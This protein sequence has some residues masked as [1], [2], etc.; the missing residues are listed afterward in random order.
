MATNRKKNKIVRIDLERY[1]VFCILPR[2]FKLSLWLQGKSYILVTPRG[3]LIIHR[4]I[5]IGKKDICFIGHYSRSCSN[6]ESW[7]H[8][9][10]SSLMQ[11]KF[12]EIANYI[13]SKYTCTYICVISTDVFL[14]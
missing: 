9:F 3:H 5:N 4:L 10:N 1:L 8:K 6:T 2:L 11:P 12:L 14:L 7:D 13:D